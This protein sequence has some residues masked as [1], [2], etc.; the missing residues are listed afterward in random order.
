MQEPIV[1]QGF[2]PQGWHAI[3]PRIVVQDVRGLVAFL[4][5]V[6]GATGVAVEGRPST[7]WIGDSAIMI[8]E[9][10]VRGHTP[11]FLYV[12]VKD[13]DTTYARA[14]AAGA[15]T[16]EEPFETPY[17]DRRCMVEDEWGNAWQIATYKGE[18]VAS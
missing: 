12:Y 10:G 16:V 7:V 8:S 4:A 3:T 5:S 9:V 11:A 18:D 1:N 2:L 6:F 15:R 14:V 17:G 13:V